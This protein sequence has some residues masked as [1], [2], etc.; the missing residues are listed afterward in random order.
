MITSLLETAPLR[1]TP[2]VAASKALAV[3]QP[4]M[5]AG[6]KIASWTC[7]LKMVRCSTTAGVL[8]NHGAT[9]M[10][11]RLPTMLGL[12]LKSSVPW[13]DAAAIGTLKPTLAQELTS[14]WFVWPSSDVMNAWTPL[15]RASRQLAV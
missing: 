9:F 3:V 13:I 12:S 4:L 2:V 6:P 10:P 8:P 11:M 15:F 7:F 5:A 1:G 14:R